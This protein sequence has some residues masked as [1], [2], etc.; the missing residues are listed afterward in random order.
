ML[1][2]LSPT[3]AQV[4][5]VLLSL[6]TGLAAALTASILPAVESLEGGSAES[7]GAVAL[8]ALI[9]LAAAAA[10]LQLRLERVPP[11]TYGLPRGAVAVGVTLAV[12]VGAP[13]AAVALDRGDAEPGAT[14][15][16]PRRPR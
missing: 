16:P 11:R 7:E 15:Q 5:A 14:R 3:R 13:L 1:V 10:A 4:R 9:V 2:A 6:G 12:L 8:A